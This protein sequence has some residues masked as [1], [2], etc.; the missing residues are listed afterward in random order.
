M[1][2]QL[3]IIGLGKIGASAGLA[4]ATRRSD[5][6]CTGHDRQP[7]VAQKAKARGALNR[8]S[9]NLPASVEGAEAVLLALPAGQVC[10]TLGHIAPALRAGAVV[11]DTAPVKAQAAA[12]MQELLPPGRYYVGLFPAL[13]PAAVFSTVDTARADLFEGGLVAV[14]APAGTPGEALE[15]AAG[16]VAGL[17]ASPL[18]A[19]LAELDGLMAVAHLLPQLA[20]AAL[21]EAA[22]SQ[23]GW[24]D[25]RKLA[26]RPFATASEPIAG[27]DDPAALAAAALAGRQDTLRALDS[28]LAALQ[29]LRAAVDNGEISTLEKRLQAACQARRH[30]Q[31]ERAGG[32]WESAA[33]RPPQLPRAG[34]FWKREL[35]LSLGKLFRPP[36][37]EPRDERR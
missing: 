11:L 30:W 18:F 33:S 12:Q 23:P 31:Q 14:A 8:I 37:K 24:S 20:A 21:M 28:L 35:G 27:Q 29:A 10:E 36:E 13:G 7:E 16:L 5:L 9:Y 1:T 6:I 4:L 17:G 25:I 3:T 34:E 15:L 32:D 22:A 19:D 2:V 26:G